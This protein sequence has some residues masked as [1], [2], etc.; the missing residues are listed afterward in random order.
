MNAV[1]SEPPRGYE[2]VST[3][4]AIRRRTSV[5]SGFLLGIAI[6]VGYV[7][8]I[9]S[10]DGALATPSFPEGFGAFLALL[11]VHEAVHVGVLTA[12]G[13]SISV[14]MTVRN[15]GSLYVVPEAQFIPRNRLLL[16]LLAPVSVLSVGLLG[17]V[18]LAG[19][20][21]VTIALLLFWTNLVGSVADVTHAL[22]VLRTPADTLYYG[23]TDT[24][25][26]YRPIPA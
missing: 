7:A 22:T 20:Q 14:G 3:A 25:T 12:Y 2:R 10:H 11:V 18:L 21:I 6:L 5:V 24:V 19:G 17:L 4:L 15:G 9:L 8:Y 23:T 1:T 26:L 13:Y 16:A